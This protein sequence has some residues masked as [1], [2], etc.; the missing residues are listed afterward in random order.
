MAVRA[1]ARASSARPVD[2]AVR[3]V[4]FPDAEVAAVEKLIA[5]ETL[6]WPEIKRLMTVPGA[7][8]L[9]SPSG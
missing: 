5:A 1:A 6:S 7:K 2:S 9:A 4:D 3:Q 8:I